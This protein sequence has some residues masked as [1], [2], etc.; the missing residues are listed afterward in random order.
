VRTFAEA[1]AAGCC[2]ARLEAYGRLDRS[3]LL[4]ADQ[5]LTAEDWRWYAL[6]DKARP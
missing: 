5:L 2:C 6:V 1:F 3:R 4:A